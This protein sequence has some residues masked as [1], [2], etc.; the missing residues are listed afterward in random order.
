MESKILSEIRRGLVG[1]HIIPMSYRDIPPHQDID[2]SKSIPMGICN[3]SYH[4]YHDRDI[5]VYWKDITIPAGR[6]SEAYSIIAQAYS[7][8]EDTILLMGV[9]EFLGLRSLAGNHL[10][11]PL[12]FLTY[13]NGLKAVIKAKNLLLSDG[14]PLSSRVD[15]VLN[16]TQYLEILEHPPT[17]LSDWYNIKNILF[18]GSIYYTPAMSPGQGL[19]LPSITDNKNYFSLKINIDSTIIYLPTDGVIRIHLSIDHIRVNN[20]NM[21]CWMENI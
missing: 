6:E 11:E 19:I 3:L 17:G 5:R 15:M 4:K 18:G 14:Y 13:G 9:S 20:L 8:M 12:D 1:R 21:I 7:L 16:P 10:G 2:F